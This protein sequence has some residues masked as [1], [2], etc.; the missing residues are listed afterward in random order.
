[1]D[2]LAVYQ[3]LAAEVAKGEIAFPSSAQVAMKVRHALDDPDCHIDHAVKLVQAEPVLA[4]RVVAIAN[5]TAYNPM[6]REI[7]EVRAAVTRLGFA[8]VRTLA[9]ALL[10]RQLAGSPSTEPAR[11]MTTRLWEHTAHVAALARILAQRVTR[12]NP[13]SAMF[14]GVIHSVGGFYMLSR[15]KD[16]PGLLDG[17]MLSWVEEG[18]VVV[19]RA[20]METL[21]I[22][23][24]IR[25]TIEAYWDGY[26]SM[27]PVSLADTLLLAEELSP[28]GSPLGP[29]GG[30]RQQDDESDTAT[31][32][33]GMAASI[34]MLIGEAMLSDILAESASEVASLT[35]ALQ[36]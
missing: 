19:G 22:P 26:L 32:E 13:E 11:S 12:Q 29:N 2:K 3:S 20:V 30:V 9:T 24:A 25:E 5:S 35:Q 15:A 31:A 7:T 4:A 1:M 14:A 18:R 28:V 8:T 16:F 34:D 23:G 17:D 33:G 10:T 21:G 6:G 27:P 36:F